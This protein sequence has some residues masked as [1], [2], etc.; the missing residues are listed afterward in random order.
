M[1]AEEEPAV[2]TDGGRA[3]RPALERGGA[4][5]W[6]ETLQRR[7]GGGGGEGGGEAGGGGGAHSASLDIEEES[8]VTWRPR[9]EANL[10]AMW[11]SPPSP[12]M[13][14]RSPSF[15]CCRSGVHTV[16]PPQSS[17]AVAALSSESGI[18]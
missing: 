15:V 4:C 5:G 13:P 2:V 14:T 7:L 1:R 11:P 3:P 18:K 12:R 8:A 10:I 16:C 9:A 6:V 17:G